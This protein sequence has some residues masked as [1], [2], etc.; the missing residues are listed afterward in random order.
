MEEDDFINI[1]TTNVN[2]KVAIKFD[3]TYI[4]SFDGKCIDYLSDSLMSSE[5]DDDPP[6]PP[7]HPPHEP[8]QESPIIYAPTKPSMWVAPDNQLIIYIKN[9]IMSHQELYCTD[10]GKIPLV[11]SDIYHNFL[12]EFPMELKCDYIQYI[13]EWM[14]T[15]FYNH[16]YNQYK[17]NLTNVVYKNIISQYEA[18]KLSPILPYNE[19]NIYRDKPMPIDT[20][21]EKFLKDDHMYFI[22]NPFELIVTL[23]KL[24][25]KMSFDRRGDVSNG[26]LPPLFQKKIYVIH[27]IR[28]L[29]DRDIFPSEL[30]C[31][32]MKKAHYLYSNFIDVILTNNEIIME[33][34]HSSSDCSGCLDMLRN[35]FMPPAHY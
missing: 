10:V 12:N 23:M 31:L 25:N 2:G 19:K 24:V 35:L 30:E 3:D 27:V 29:A 1:E 4:D 15:T 18:L 8:E 34:Y 21:I 13:L 17:I 33:K 9:H 6:P 32:I 14:N 28:T 5:S 22:H 16:L 20:F 11:V 7:P 26:G